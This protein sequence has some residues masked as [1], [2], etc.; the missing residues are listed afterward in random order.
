ME[1]LAPQILAQS[2]EVLEIILLAA[3]AL[4]F[5][6]AVSLAAFPF[7]FAVPLA[8]R[9]RKRFCVATMFLDVPPTS[10]WRPLNF[11]SP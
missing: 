5:A 6:F 11:L 2:H 4:V 1:V 3:F 10:R 7:P 8:G 9:C